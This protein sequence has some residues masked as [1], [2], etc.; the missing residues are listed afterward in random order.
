MRRGKRGKRHGYISTNDS[1]LRHFFNEVQSLFFLYLLKSPYFLKMF[2]QWTQNRHENLSTP[3]SNYSFKNSLFNANKMVDCM[4]TQTFSVVTWHCLVQTNRQEWCG[5]NTEAS[6]DNSYWTGS[7]CKI[8]F[9]IVVAVNTSMATHLILFLPYGQNWFLTSN[10][11]T[12]IS[13]R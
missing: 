9:G 12:H 13:H 11:Y 1:V 5:N 8:S 4:E 7:L 2:S 3:N 6:N 10:H